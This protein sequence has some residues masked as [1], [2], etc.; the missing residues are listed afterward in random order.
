MFVGGMPEAVCAYIAAKDYQ[1]V[2][3]VQ[4]SILNAYELDFSKHAPKNEVIRINQVWQSIVAQL[5]KENKKFIY[6]LLR[7]GARAK[8]FEIALQ[9]LIE[10]RLVYKCKHIS[11]P[12]LPMSAYSNMDYFKLYFIDIG[13][14]GCLAKLDVKTILL[15]NDLF[16]EF[17]GVLVENYIASALKINF[18]ELYYWSSEGKAEIDFVIQFEDKIYPLEVKSGMTSK[19]KSLQVYKQKFSPKR[20]LRCSPNNLKLDANVL[21]CPL[22]LVAL[23]KNYIKMAVM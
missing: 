9:W 13:L 16:Q 3:A 12:K 23:I 10:A 14:L 22:Y 20:S 19:K 8:E 21:N 2:R 1:K 7:T 6:S 17:K 18:D 11:V 15:G 4:R 5:A